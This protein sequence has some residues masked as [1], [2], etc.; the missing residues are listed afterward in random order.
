MPDDLRNEDAVPILTAKIHRLAQQ[1]KSDVAFLR[2]WLEC[3]MEATFF[4]NDCPG[5]MTSPEN[6]T[7]EYEIGSEMP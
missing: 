1:L 7:S 5:I 4:L 3:H 2:E 6:P